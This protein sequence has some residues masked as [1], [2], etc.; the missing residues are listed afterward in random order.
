MQNS[1]NNMQPGSRPIDMQNVS[2]PGYTQPNS[3]PGGNTQPASRMEHM[4]SENMQSEN[5]QLT[6]AGFWV[7]LGA[8]VIDSLVVFAGLLIV[9]LGMWIFMSVLG[10]TFLGGHILFHYTLKDIVLYMAQ[11]LYFIL[12]TYYTGTTLGKRAMNL[13]VIAAEDGKKLTFLNVVYR[14]TI[15]R[16]LSG[17]ILGIGYIMIGID[18]EKRGLHDILCDTRVIYGKKVKVY[19]EYNRPAYVPAQPNGPVPR[20]ASVPPQP[21]VLPQPSVPPQPIVTPHPAVSPQDTMPVQSEVPLQSPEQQPS[22]VPDADSAGSDQ[23]S[24][25]TKE[26]N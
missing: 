2:R 9:R 6:Y 7:R 5:M 24:T 19:P 10:D 8:Y 21:S 22:S 20:P 18:K 12:C 11:V 14:E 25:P 3:R 16:F 23:S 1:Y 15:G 13:R 4:Q 17:F 26:E